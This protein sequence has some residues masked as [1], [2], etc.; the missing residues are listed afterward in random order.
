M[1]MGFCLEMGFRS[2]SSVSGNSKRYSEFCGD[3]CVLMICGLVGSRRFG[4][5]L[6]FGLILGEF[7]WWVYGNWCLTFLAYFDCFA[8]FRG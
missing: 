3:V 2:S 5:Q 8:V 7:G 1:I 4:L 6:K